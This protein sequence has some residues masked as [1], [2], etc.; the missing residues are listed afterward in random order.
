MSK[1]SVRNNR[2]PREGGPSQAARQMLFIL[3]VL[4][5]D[6]PLYEGTANP[7][8]VA[9]RRARN[10]VARISRRANRG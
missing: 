6:I 2:K 8:A 5:R 9:K 10:K 7:K 1:R 3:S 4:R